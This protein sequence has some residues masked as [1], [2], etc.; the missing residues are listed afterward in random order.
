MSDEQSYGRPGD[1]RLDS[2]DVRRVAATV[3]VVVGCALLLVG[4]ITL[5]AR[6]EIFNPDHFATRASTALQNQDVRTVLADRIVEEIINEGS[7]ELIQAKPLLQAIVSNV[8]DTGPFRTIFR[9]AAVQVHRALFARDEGSI[10]FDLADTGTVVISAAKAVA[11]GVAKKIPSD[12][13]PEL[14]KVRE[15]TFATETLSIADNV[16]FLGILLP[17]LALACFVAA[18]RGRHRPSP[19]DGYAR[20]RGRD[21]RRARGHRLHRRAGGA[22]LPLP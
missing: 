16:R 2:G 14:V 11:P 8:L 7:S 19:G 3:L 10:V 4:G 22:A 17:L 6:E 15:R 20:S 9:K 21:G 5:Y 1:G 13:E 18:Y 12:V